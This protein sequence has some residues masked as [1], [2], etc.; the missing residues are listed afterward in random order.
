MRQ[1]AFNP[2]TRTLMTTIILAHSRPPSREWL[3]VAF[4]K[5]EA[6]A[7]AAPCTEEQKGKE[8]GLA[9][10]CRCRGCFERSCFA[11][12]ARARAEGIT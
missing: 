7:Q 11:F 4:A 1:P 3:N 5:W 12:F 6:G 8:Y 10:D 2:R 9:T